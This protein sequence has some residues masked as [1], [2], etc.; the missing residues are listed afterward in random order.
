MTDSRC[1]ELFSIWKSLKNAVNWNNGF[2]FQER[3]EPPD[4]LDDLMQDLKWMS[5]DLSITVEGNRK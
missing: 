4:N 2:N 5:A 1:E 3:K